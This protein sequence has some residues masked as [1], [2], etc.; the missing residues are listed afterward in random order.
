[1]VV[2]VGVVAV[3][4][5]GDLE[6]DLD[7]PAGDADVLDD[8]AQELLAAVEVEVVEGRERAL[9]EAGEAAAQA[10]AAGE[11]GARSVSSF[12]GEL[13]AAVGEGGGAAG[14]LVEVEQFGLVGVEQSV[15]LALGLVELARER[16]ELGA[17]EVVVVGWR[18][19]MTACSPA[20]SWAG[21]SSARRTWANT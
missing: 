8:E 17:D 1:L 7:V 5:E 21:S 16:G 13:L 6:V 11:F 10:V 3:V 4:G 20:I 12:G 18:G 9:G 14:E 19:V 15:A 2:V